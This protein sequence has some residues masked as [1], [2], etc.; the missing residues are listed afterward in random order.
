MCT[1]TDSVKFFTSF[2]MV[3][4]SR[5]LHELIMKSFDFYEELIPLLD[6]FEES[7]KSCYSEKWVTLSSN[8]Q[9]QL[10][11]QYADTQLILRQEYH[12][13]RNFIVHIIFDLFIHQNRHLVHVNFSLD[14]KLKMRQQHDKKTSC[15]LSTAAK[16]TLKH[17]L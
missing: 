1:Q 5:H 12:F 3:I 11:E 7:F 8:L 17:H 2:D 16:A 6:S 15:V 13:Y 9:Q 10:N 4:S 14:Q